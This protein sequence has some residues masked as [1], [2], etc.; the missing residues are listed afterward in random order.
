MNILYVDFETYYDKTY[1]LSKITTEEYI[2]SPLFEVI[3]VSVAVNDNEPVWFSGTLEETRKFLHTFDWASSMAVAHNALFDM[4]ILNWVFGIHPH[5]IGDTLAMGRALHGV[6]VGGSLAALAQF[7]GIG[8]KGNEVVQALGKHRGG[9]TSSELAAYGRYCVNDTDLC[10]QL[11]E[12]MGKGFSVLEFKLVDLTTRMFTEPEL[13]LDTGLLTTHLESVKQKKEKLMATVEAHKDDL[14]SNPKFAEL[15]Q[16]MGVTPPVKTSLTTGKETYAFA[17]TDDGFKEL[18][19][20][21]DLR[22]QTLAAAR[23]GVK[24]TL[25][26]TRLERLIAVAERGRLPVPLK[27]YA[28]HTGRWGGQDQ[29]NLQNIPRK[30]VIKKAILAPEDYI[31]I[32]ADSSQIEA[33]TL[34]W[35][36]EQEDLV[37]A[38]ELNNKEIAAGI[39][40]E[41]HQH[42]PYKI[43]ARKIYG[44]PEKER[45]SDDARFVGKSAILG[46]G[47]GI[48]ATKFHTQL[49]AFNV[50]KSM[51]ECE[52]I[53]KTYRET[54]SKIPE[55]WRTANKAIQAIMTDQYFEFGRDGL[56]KVEGSRGIRLP[57]GMYLQYPQLR[58]E[59]TEDG[60]Q[61]VYTSVL[62]R[63]KVNKKI[64]SAKIIENVCQSL[65]RIIIGEQMLNISKK[66][67]VVMTVHDSVVSLAHKDAKVEAIKYVES[68]MRQRPVW[69][70]GLPLNCEVKTGRSYG[71]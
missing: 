46:A 33:R 5:R 68:C 26:E 34:A 56:L 4:A 53:V 2:R 45:V 18:L 21:P 42:D 37:E 3:G 16:S 65:A 41:D 25:E 70:L 64:Y 40:K 60:A 1:S 57:N 44:I 52:H 71:G 6:S 47:Y 17:K 66:Y 13:V 43:M 20:H 27:Y 9:F 51:E 32:D 10:R 63:S 23:I 12:R 14:M 61:Y 22:V 24:S 30:S 59:D 38:F 62:G 29:I 19:E 69:C 36:A 58:K 49:K 39:P 54:Y 50:V 11:F 67:R 35:L 31:I 55:L 8:E 7:Y 28:A 48:G 15:L